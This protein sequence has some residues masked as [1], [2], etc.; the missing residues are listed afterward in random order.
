MLG[1]CLDCKDSHRCGIECTAKKCFGE[2]CRCTASE[3]FPD[4]WQCN[5]CEI[6]ICRND[7]VFQ[8]YLAEIFEYYNMFKEQH[9]AYLRKLEEK[10]CTEIPLSVRDKEIY[11]IVDAFVCAKSNFPSD[12]TAFPALNTISSRKNAFALIQAFLKMQ[13]IS[14]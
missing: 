10:R 3:I 6:I 2:N 7:A 11:D 8:K 5:T 4:L 1:P 9:N 14:I 12:P 13:E